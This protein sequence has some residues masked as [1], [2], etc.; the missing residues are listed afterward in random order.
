MLIW[1]YR[2]DSI[3]SIVPGEVAELLAKYV[4][5]TRNEPEWWMSQSKSPINE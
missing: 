1:T 2:T 5:N 3:F 4:W